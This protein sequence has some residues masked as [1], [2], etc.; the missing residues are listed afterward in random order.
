MQAYRASRHSW[1]I[2]STLMVIG[3]LLST[4]LAF[5]STSFGELRPV[6]YGDADMLIIPSLYNDVRNGV[7]ITGWRVSLATFFF[8]D[9]VLYF[10]IRA[11]TKNMFTALPIYGFVQFGLFVGGLTV[12]AR[13]VLPE[14]Y[15]QKNFMI[16]GMMSAL[17]LS[18]YEQIHF[19]NQAF[20]TVHHFGV[21]V[22]IPWALAL[23]YQLT[24]SSK[25]AHRL[26]LAL[27][28]LSALA[29]FSDL[30][31]VIQFAMPISVG[32]MALVLM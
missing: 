5:Y 23:V 26:F 1:R 19:A 9:I 25:A 11:L 27:F 13:Q 7:D 18:C 15:K 2:L 21:L 30:F 24:L 4:V 3:A 12:F 20:L 32:L 28:S 29:S 10:L 8:P 31:Y 16:I 22:V 6:L 14:D 17:F